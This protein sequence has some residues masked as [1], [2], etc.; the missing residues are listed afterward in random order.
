VGNR[1][2]FN[3]EGVVAVNFTSKEVFMDIVNIKPQK[4][5]LY[6]NTHYQPLIEH[7]F[8]VG[9]VAQQLCLA[10]LTENK[11][12]FALSAFI[13]GCLH[14]VG[15]IDPQF[16]TW[17]TKDKSKTFVAEDGQHIDDNKFSFDKHP[18][19]NEISYVAFKA[20]EQHAGKKS[21]INPAHKRYIEH[22]IYWHHAKPFRKNDKGSKK[23][24]SL[25]DI[26]EVFE[27]S[28]NNKIQAFFESGFSVL[29]K[30]DALAAT[31]TSTHESILNKLNWSKP[32]SQFVEELNTQGIGLPAF[33]V[34]S[35]NKETFDNFA[36]EAKDNG[37]CNVIR[38]CVITADRL[39]S[40]LSAP[41][42]L[43]HIKNNS[44]LE[45]VTKA[46]TLE[47]NL[48][49]QIKDYLT[50]FPNSER[51]Q[52]QHEIA[53]EL[54]DKDSVSVLAGAAGCGK[55]KIALEWATLKNAQQII[56][57]CPRV[58]V[59]QGIFDELTQHYLPN[60]KIEIATGEFKFTNTWDNKTPEKDYFSADI[61]ITTIDQILSAIISHSKIDMLIQ[62]MNAHVVF[63]EYHEYVTEPAFTLLFA[64]LIAC[65]KLRERQANT[66][67]VSATPH[68]FYLKEVLGIDSDDVAVMPSFN[69][70]LYK[71]EFCHFDSKIR[72]E[73]NPFYKPQTDKTFVISNTAKTA[74]LS[75]IQN[76]QQEKGS[77]LLHSKFKKS[78]KKQLFEEVYDSFKR[79][80]T[81]KYRILRSGPIVQA[82]LNIS[83][84]YMVS[85]MT[86]AEN[87][88]QRLGR[89]N[90]FGL[91]KDTI[92]VLTIAI[93]DSVSKGKCVDGSAKFLHSLNSLQSA[94]A[95]YDLLAQ[96]DEQPI[97]LAQLYQIYTDF[98]QS[99]QC[100]TAVRSDLLAAI[101]TSINILTNKVNE[102]L[103]MPSKKAQTEGRAKISKNSLR[104]DNRFVQMAVCDV[105]NPTQPVVLNRYTYQ[106]AVNDTEQFDNLT[107]SLDTIRN[108]GLVDYMAQRHAR[109]DKTSIIEGIPAN[110]V[111]VRKILL[112]NFARDPEYPLYLSY[113]PDDLLHQLGEKTA[114][115]EAI[116][117]VECDKQPIG[118][119]AMKDLLNNNED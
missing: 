33:K 18:R 89:L 112:E 56:W 114:P 12:K 87:I 62:F 45:L 66:L 7:L 40:A 19:H 92:S 39:V 105:N 8:A 52:K 96:L 50:Q 74:Q 49:S 90:R 38:A 102:P 55:T 73:S 115:A 83:C 111:T 75:F 110:K 94:K 27:A 6:A 44:L 119:I 101:K 59:C 54:S 107:E 4:D 108:Y 97:K 1:N 63:D 15:K 98:Y 95:W 86:T 68:Y 34:Y 51:T 26:Y 65:K 32:E 25:N 29:E 28:L 84:D 80:G 13:V 46:L 72:D 81:N 57:I 53:K 118:M 71:I 64:E 106:F 41:A 109:I 3:K 2:K 82:S 16:Q 60:T 30:V 17:V 48:S 93:T 21:A 78:D 42:L 116:Y 77:I 67:L 100:Q 103:V 47:S 11:E 117:Y 79:D 99:E 35:P 69:E 24:D 9:Y 76:Q 37:N 31:Y 23:F 113:T 61:I 58:Q 14:D 43:H 70:C 20:F 88:L 5:V 104:G 85:E 91:N 10:V 22:V 36:K